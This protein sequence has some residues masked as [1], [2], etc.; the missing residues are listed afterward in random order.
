MCVNF[1]DLSKAC[2][3]DYYPLSHI[4]QLIDSTAGHQF[5]FMMDPYHGYHQ[6]P[7]AQEDQDKVSFIMAE[8]TFGYAVT[9]FEL[10]IC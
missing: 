8:G 4:D 6:I 7:L 5:I 10:K 2:P 3:K 9:L 1:R